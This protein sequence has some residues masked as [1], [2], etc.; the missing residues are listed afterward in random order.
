MKSIGNLGDKIVPFVLSA[1]FVTGCAATD[2]QSVSSLSDSKNNPSCLEKSLNVNASHQDTVKDSQALKT[3]DRIIERI[4]D[5]DETDVE[6][7][8]GDDLAIHESDGTITRIHLAYINAPEPGQT[9][10]R[11][12]HK[13]IDYGAKAKEHLQS[14]IDNSNLLKLVVVDIDDYGKQ[15]AYVIA[16]GSLV[17]AKMIRVGLAYP[18]K[19]NKD[20][21]PS[22][23]HVIAYDNMVSDAA[24]S[25]KKPPY[26]HPSGYEA[27]LRKLARQSGAAV[28]GPVQAVSKS[29]SPAKDLQEKRNYNNDHG[30]YDR[31]SEIMKAKA[32]NR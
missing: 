24:S 26:A 12:K 21:F 27:K 8:N 7:V 14:I 31:K 11:G 17:Q 29:D 19:Y 2:M 15:V 28:I 4:I 3:L 5:L 6:V 10:S 30:R 20:R 1:S 25:L 18:E 32:L 16:D 23:W 9:G 22:G 13:K